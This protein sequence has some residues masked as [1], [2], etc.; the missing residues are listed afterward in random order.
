MTQRKEKKIT[1]TAHSNSCIITHRDILL[2]L[3]LSLCSAPQQC[4]STEK[5]SVMQGWKGF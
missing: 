3:V 2:H 5:G 4:V 1:A